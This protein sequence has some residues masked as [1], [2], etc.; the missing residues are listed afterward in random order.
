MAKYLLDTTVLINH[1]RGHRRVADFLRGLADQGHQLGVCAINIAELYAGLRPE[2]QALADRLIDSM[3]FYGITLGVSKQAG[4]Y[5][6][7]FAGQG[8][9]LSTADT[10]IAATA[11]AE[12][13]TLV[14]DNSRDFPMEELQLLEHP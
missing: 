5:R 2:E 4:R 11:I 12:D 1:S 6:Y 7:E 10:L 14:T 9:S 8:L 3:D 13:A